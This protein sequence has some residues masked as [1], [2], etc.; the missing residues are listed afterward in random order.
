MQVTLRIPKKLYKG[1]SQSGKS[2]N[3]QTSI[4]MA[5]F[6]SIPKIM[7]QDWKEYDKPINDVYSEPYI[8]IV[9]LNK[10]FSLGKVGSN[11]KDVLSNVDNDKIEVTM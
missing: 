8:Q 3:F 4:R 7:V 6:F 1:L 9:F 5:N 10:A 2:H 11:L